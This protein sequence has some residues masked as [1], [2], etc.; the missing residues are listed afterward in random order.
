MKKEDELGLPIEYQQLPQFFDAHN[1]NEETEAKNALIEKLLKEQGVKTV[2]DMTCG[3]G[4]Q[5]LYLAQRGYKITGSDLCPD[6]IKI[7]RNKAKKKKLDVQ[8]IEGDMRHIKVGQFDAVITIF[9]AIGH[10][11]KSEFEKTLQNIRHN[12]NP[13]GTYIFDIFN[14][15][16]LTEDVVQNFK[17][18]IQTE[19]NGVKFRNQQYSEIDRE[20]GL[21]ISHDKYM[22]IKDDSEPEY[23]TNTFSLQMYTAKELRE[24][25]EKTGF[26]V[27]NQYDME[28]QLLIPDK[29][30]HILTVAKVK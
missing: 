12:L 13:G 23:K 6:L 24:L 8:F 16:A 29:S 15:Q 20:K 19:V 17:M 18:D 28:G 21:L 14:L 1:I 9:S 25:L 4:S 2:L 5:V 22:I 30:H 10:V 11:S 3:T 27:L 7:A 26:E